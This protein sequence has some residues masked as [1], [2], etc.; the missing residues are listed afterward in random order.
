MPISMDPVNRKDLLVD[1]KADIVLSRVGV[2]NENGLAGLVAKTTGNYSIL[3][4]MQ[5]VITLCLKTRKGE[6]PKSLYFG[7]SP[8]D[9]KTHMTRSGLESLRLY[10]LENLRLSGINPANYR[11][12]VS[13]VPLTQDSVSIQV[14]AIVVVNGIQNILKVNNIF[15]DN[16]GVVTPVLAYGA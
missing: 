9:V 4:T 10:I 7:A 15:N 13:I 12:N 8:K 11:L 1:S 14:S 5:Q 16:T 2:A 3:E 6:N